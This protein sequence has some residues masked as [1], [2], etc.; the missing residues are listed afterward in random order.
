MLTD[1]LVERLRAKLGNG[2]SD[3][4]PPATPDDVQQAEEELGWTLPAAVV[5]YFTR[6]GNGARDF[7]G[8]PGGGTDDL[9]NDAVQL[10][11]HARLPDPDE[12][13]S[14]SGYVPRDDVLAVAYWGCSVYSWVC[15]DGTMMASDGWDWIPDGRPFHE[16]LD[17]LADGTLRQPC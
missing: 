14:E 6:V 17:A 12:A 11:L 3:L 4:A 9:G 15:R 13:E 16:W 5:D 8:L 2:S 10:G 1:D 7:P